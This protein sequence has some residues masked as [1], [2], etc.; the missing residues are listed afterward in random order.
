MG[1]LR[2]FFLILLTSAFA[3]SSQKLLS[4][5]SRVNSREADPQSIVLNVSTIHGDYSEVETDLIVAAP[6]PLVI[7]R[8]YSSKD[9]AQWA[10]FG[11]WRFMPHCY[12]RVENPKGELRVSVGTS[13][14]SILT[15]TKAARNNPD[16]PDILFQLVTEGMGFAN[17]AKGRITAS[18]NQKNCALYYSE[19]KDSYE[20]VL[21]SGHIRQYVKHSSLN[22]Y[23]LIKEVTPIG[24]NIAY[25]YD[26]E[27]RLIKIHE[28]NLPE[29]KTLAWI[30]FQYSDGI[31]VE[32]CDGQKLKYLFDQRPGQSTHLR[33]VNR[34]SGP[35][36]AYH[37]LA[38]AE[39][40]LLI[41]KELPGGTLIE[42]SYL[43]DQ[44]GSVESVSTPISGSPSATTNFQFDPK[45]GATEVAGPEGQKSRYFFD[46]NLMLTAIEQYLNGSLYRVHKKYWGISQNGS[47]LS[48]LS[49]DDDQGNT[50]YYKSLGYDDKGNILEEKEYGNLTGA[51]SDPIHFDRNGDPIFEGEPHVKTFSYSTNSKRDIIDQKDA[52]GT[53]IRYVYLKDR[54]LLAKK[55]LLENGQRRIRHSYEYNEDGA[56]TRV[57]TDDGSSGDS[58][59]LD[60]VS[61][62][63]ITSITPKP[64]LPNA[65]F[66]MVVEERWIDTRYGDE[67]PLKTTVNRFD[68]SGRVIAQKTYDANQVL[69][70]SLLYAYNAQGQLERQCDALGL[71]T[72]YA[73]DE[74]FNIKSQIR[75]GKKISYAYDL[76]GRMINIKEESRETEALETHLAYD[77]QGHKTHEIDSL[78]NTTQYKY[79]GLGRLI[80]IS[81]P[82]E[83]ENP[84]TV[85]TYDLF[86]SITSTQ[87]PLGNATHQ[88]NTVKGLPTKISHPDG[89]TEIFKY[90]PEGSLHR[91]CGIDGIIK[92]YE[93][94]YQGRITLIENYERGND[95]KKHGF[96]REHYGYNAFHCIKRREGYGWDDPGQEVSYKYDFAGRL[97]EEISRKTKIDYTYDSLGRIGT[98]KSWKSAKDFS[99]HVNE[100][101]NTNLLIEERIENPQGKELFKRRYR[102]DV[103][104][105]LSQIIGYPENQES[106]LAQYTYDGLGR[107]SKSSEGSDQ[108]EISYE[109]PFGR[110]Q[111]QILKNPLGTRFEKSFNMM[112]NLSQYT[113]KSSNGNLLTQSDFSYDSVGNPIY[114]AH[115]PLTASYS[116][117]NYEI[118]RG[119]TAG[120]QLASIARGGRGT[121]SQ[122]FKY[123][124]HREL[125]EE[126]FEHRDPLTYKYDKMGRLLSVDSNQKKQMHKF[127]YTEDGKLKEEW[128]DR[129]LIDYEWDNEDLLQSEVI[130]DGE[131]VHFVCYDWDKTGAIIKITLPDSSYIEYSYDGP[132]V[133]IIERYS[134]QGQL[135]YIHR[136]NARDLMGNPL[137]E[138]LPGYLG[139]KET[140]YNSLGRKTGIITNYFEEQIP[141]SGIDAAGNMRHLET[142]LNGQQTST[143]FEY[144]L[145]DQLTAEKGEREYEYSYDALGNRL[146]KNEDSYELDSF[147]RLTSSGAARYSYDSKGN[148]SKSEG[149]GSNKYTFDALGRLSSVLS[150]DETLTT[151]SYDFQ[152]RRL[153]KC[154]APYRKQPVGQYYFY[155]GA[156]ELGAIDNQGHITELRIPL[157]P[158]NPEEGTLV[159][160]ELGQQVYVPIQDL[161]S[162]VRCLVELTQR[163]VVES[164]RYTAF[165]EETIFDEMGNAMAQS[166]IGNPWRFW[167]KRS[168]SESTLLYFGQRYYDPKVGRWISADPLGEIDGPNLY[169]FVHNNPLKYTDY[170]GYSSEPTDQF[171]NYFYGEYEPH[172][173]CET[174]RTCKRGGDIAMDILNSPRLQGTFQA[175]GGLA[176]ASFGGG[177]TLAT[178][179]ATAPFGW[180]VMAHGLDQFITGISTAFT[181]RPRDTLTSQLLQKTGMSHQTASFI[182]SGL[183]MGG[184]MGS[185][186]VIRFS[187][188]A[189]FPNFRLPTQGPQTT[190]YRAV[191]PVELADIQKTGIFRNL[192][193]AEGK[194]FTTS[195][196]GAS[197]YAKK[198]VTGFG[199]PPYTLVKTQ[200]PNNILNGIS[201]T[202]VD[203]GIPAWVIHDQSLEGLIPEIVTWMA[204]PK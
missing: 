76:Q 19:G 125:V 104:G 15:F 7:T 139:K 130:T 62:R 108:Y 157:N 166:L 71:E 65:G 202:F 115:N 89:A 4:V 126:T 53:G 117:N 192:G 204:V 32:A 190:L 99:L 154:S 152:G 110:S 45:T 35:D 195:I 36:L 24:N 124:N 22:L 118:R 180:P 98:I 41:K 185:A 43:N 44:K 128:T 51:T 149:L 134:K 176:E 189:A 97:I 33:E 203:G 29:D 131:N 112:G 40:P 26:S 38:Q 67:I 81:T 64:D 103:E 25:S 175:L 17:T 138:T 101:D 182:D 153:E 140:H 107:V 137:E 54:Q 12:L 193:D 179:G 37:Y 47:N 194:Y 28:T 39:H 61:E 122:R 49:V 181:G 142:A 82:T 91:Y 90:D 116:E 58:T 105:R 169:C 132:Y 30:K 114:E 156:Y 46:S 183:S 148:F 5:E 147:N 55:V 109:L 50:F 69:Q 146:S 72:S 20:H 59:R 119:Y 57:T 75:N 170:W 159:A 184:T 162:S 52:K 70:H 163:K 186:A 127:K 198:A 161:Q 87:D 85:F 111:Q 199:D 21:P 187:R 172:C 1:T 197:S 155:L 88:Q 16:R 80:S 201:P 93:Y 135:L 3:L 8:Y 165:G 56:L 18:T 150:V 173:H 9:N 196:E 168:D 144:N 13:E 120:G 10:T 177:M 63:S 121:Q 11:G 151:Y 106:V 27:G 94:D 68:D 113:S 83:T 191:Q 141:S 200:V 31:E 60:S 78:G 92:V 34:S 136:V 145:L 6:D 73:Y 14:G 86:D 100:Y 77:S 2:I 74:D 143:S 23:L 123:N 102:Y 167:G 42:I 171:S 84:I 95:G 178:Y 188:L 129:F 158:N 164:Y 79:D 66:P 133:K 160:I 96:S 48:A 174:H